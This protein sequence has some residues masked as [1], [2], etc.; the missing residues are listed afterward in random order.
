[1][2]DAPS[3]PVRIP[4]FLPFDCSMSFAGLHW[5]TQPLWDTD[6][7]QEF[8]QQTAPLEEVNREGG[9]LSFSISAMAFE[10]M[11]CIA[12]IKSRENN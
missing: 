8:V 9:D 3:V 1:M 5:T 10:S 2:R 11:L 7:L 4:T 6:K 12:S